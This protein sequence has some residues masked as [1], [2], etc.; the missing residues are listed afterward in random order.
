MYCVPTLESTR[1]PLQWYK[2]ALKLLSLNIYYISS[3]HLI[4]N[5]SAMR[6]GELHPLFCHTVTTF[7]S[8]NQIF[9]LKANSLLPR[10]QWLVISANRPRLQPIPFVIWSHFL[11]FCFFL[12]LC[13][14]AYWLEQSSEPKRGAAPEVKLE[15]KAKPKIGSRTWKHYQRH[16]GPKGWVHLSKVTYWVTHKFTDQASKSPLQVALGPHQTIQQHFE[17]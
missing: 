13:F 14:F 10:T 17:L 5:L 8:N 12:S 4:L 1:T 15:L 9:D 16:K 11:P 7:V 3:L 6:R 2:S